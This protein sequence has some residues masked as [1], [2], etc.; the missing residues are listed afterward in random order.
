MLTKLTALLA[1]LAL[2]ACADMPDRLES[3][4]DALR[5]FADGH[6][7]AANGAVVVAR[8]ALH[9]SQ[10][11]RVVCEPRCRLGLLPLAHPPVRMGELRLRWSTVDARDVAKP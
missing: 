5:G 8:A 1:L 6:P 10:S 2:S 7:L 9:K 4:A 3:A 11:V